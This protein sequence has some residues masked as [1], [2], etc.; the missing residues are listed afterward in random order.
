MTVVV[1]LEEVA[2]HRAIIETQP[3]SQ[4]A[5]DARAALERWLA[6]P[7]LTIPPDVRAAIEAALAI[8]DP[9]TLR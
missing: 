5:F 2:R 6:D 3:R 8:P 4:H 1:T 7:G 9:T